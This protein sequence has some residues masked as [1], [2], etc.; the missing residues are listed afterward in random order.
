[1][2]GGGYV[3]SIRKDRYENVYS[4]STTSHTGCYREKGYHVNN[5]NFLIVNTR[6]KSI[7]HSCYQHECKKRTRVILRE[8]FDEDIFRQ[9]EE[10]FGEEKLLPT[11]D[12]SKTIESATD[13]SKATKSSDTENRANIIDEDGKELYYYSSDWLTQTPQT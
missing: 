5:R 7:C 3:T 10:L 1:M 12:C 8:L 11:R 4:V 9:I 2:Q 13:C 6:L